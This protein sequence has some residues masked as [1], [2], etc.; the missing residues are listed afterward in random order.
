MWALLTTITAVPGV[1]DIAWSTNNSKNELILMQCCVE[2]A[3]LP[4]A[5]FLYASDVVPGAEEAEEGLKFP[6]EFY[7]TQQLSI[8]RWNVSSGRMALQNPVEQLLKRFVI[9]LWASSV[10]VTPTQYKVI[11]CHDFS[12]RVCGSSI[13]RLYL[14]VNNAV[15]CKTMGCQVHIFHIGNKN[16]SLINIFSGFCVSSLTKLVKRRLS[17]R[18]WLPERNQKRIQNS[19]S[20]LA[21]YFMYMQ[22]HIVLQRICVWVCA[23]ISSACLTHVSVSVSSLCII[24]WNFIFW[25]TSLH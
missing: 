16:I 17:F 22:M 15:R 13:Y 4:Q 20:L 10:L 3:A 21:L 2:T 23:Q 18:G 9:S 11:L 8:N 19:P 7:I 5:S 12:A 6:N 24:L 14:G 1:T 25:Q